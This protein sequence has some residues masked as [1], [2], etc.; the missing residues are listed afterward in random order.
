MSAATPG[1]LCVVLLTLLLIA[2]R[3]SSAVTTDAEGRLY[4]R[5]TEEQPVDTLVANVAGDAGISTDGANIRYFLTNNDGSLFRIDD[6]GVLRTDAVIDRDALCPRQPVCSRYLDVGVIGASTEVTYVSIHVELIDLNDNAPSFTSPQV[7]LSLPESTP[8]GKLFPLPRADDPDSPANGVVGYRLS[9]RSDVFGIQVQ[10][11]STGD[12]DV[13]LVLKRQLDRQQED[14]YTFSLI[15]F[16][17]GSPQLS[18]SVV[19]NIFVNDVRFIGFY[20]AKLRVARYCHGKLSVRL[21]VCPSVCDVEV[22]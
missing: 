5:L 13:K 1:N 21:S 7:N 11:L 19:V 8:P 20:R 16:D 4:Y 6:E 18:G 10:N 12:V 9:P 2:G 15:A 17:G 14:R 22:S 3:Q